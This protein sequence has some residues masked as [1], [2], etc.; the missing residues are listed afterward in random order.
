VR[1]ALSDTVT[2]HAAEHQ[3]TFKNN[4]TSSKD[5][6]IFILFIS[7]LPMNEDIFICLNITCGMWVIKS[8][9]RVEG[10]IQE[11]VGDHP[12]YPIE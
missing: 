6:D 12:E 4:Q 2:A 8:M 10:Q 11:Q 3:L 1:G 5:E 9:V 7:S